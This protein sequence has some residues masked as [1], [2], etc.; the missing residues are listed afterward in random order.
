[1]KNLKVKL[2]VG[3]RRDQEHTIDATEAHKAYYLFLNPDARGV[4]DNGLAIRGEQ[5]Q[6]IVPDWNATM[7]WN[8]SHTLAGED[9]NEIR[10][11]GLENEMRDTLALAK[12]VSQNIDPKQLNTP[13]DKLVEENKSLELSEEV[14]ALGAAKRA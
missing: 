1:M 5:I 8:A 3:F 2:I 9:W 12:H 14:M 13:L 6:E 11:S 4:F 10:N 7:G